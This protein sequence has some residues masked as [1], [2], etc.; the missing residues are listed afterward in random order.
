MFADSQ[1]ASNA[2]FVTL[3]QENA[4][5]VLW[6]LVDTNKTFVAFDENNDTSLI[7]GGFT[8]DRTW[9]IYAVIVEVVLLAGLCVLG[10]LMLKGIK[11]AKAAESEPA[12]N[13][14]AN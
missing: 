8:Y 5:N 3:A 13:T 7:K 11:A 2:A 12:Q 4:H 6:T 1:Y 10:F 14:T 9:V